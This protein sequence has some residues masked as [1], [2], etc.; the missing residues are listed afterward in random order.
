MT[1]YLVIALLLAS[2]VAA[3]TPDVA[4]VKG[5]V[6]K[7]VVTRANPEQS[8]ALYLPEAYDPAKQWPIVFAFDPGARGWVPVDLAKD[9]AETFGYIV[10][11]SNNSRNGPPGPEAEAADA[12][13]NDAHE[14]F[15]IDPR[16]VY[17]AG[18][19]GGSRLAVQLAVNCKHCAT[20]VIASGAAFPTTMEPKP[21]A[22]FLY[23]GSYGRE[24]FNYSEYVDIEAKLKRAGYAY[25]LR[26]FEG[27]HEWA[28]A[29]VWSEALAWFNLQAMKSGAL[30]R[31]EAFV[32]EQ[33][34]AA[35]TNAAAQSDD[36]DRLRAYSQSVRDFAGL[37][38]VGAAQKLAGALD[39]SKSVQQLLRREQQDIREQQTL[40]APIEEQLE[41]LK[42][43]DRRSD[44]RV[45]LDRAFTRV[46][47]N[48]RSK[49]PHRQAVAKRARQQAFIE[50][51]ETASD[52]IADKH[53]AE[54]LILMD[55]V[56]QAAAHAPGAHIQKS[57][58]YMLMD[59][60]SKAL[61]E[62]RLAVKD[63]VTDPEAFSDPE[64][65]PLRS[66][67]AF[68]ALFP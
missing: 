55:V 56:V 26:R 1:R 7:R 36:L 47:E 68:K 37:A 38:D 63:G 12:M 13:W 4:F 3:Q 59:K 30:A 58:I 9:A 67:P 18:F 24:D 41:A 61:A 39:G 64:F 52:Q 27:G 31:N 57:R 45:E 6:I 66:D 35:M 34:S 49:D 40:T 2:S 10:V 14:R 25:H 22:Q 20:G 29:D 28:P 43:P 16:R 50:M 65:A 32:A 8:Y 19:S 53:Y 5:Q 54:A 46:N 17:F 62:A 44:A 48:A 23:F 33:L 60:E 51:F 42:N 11:G 21:P 15:S